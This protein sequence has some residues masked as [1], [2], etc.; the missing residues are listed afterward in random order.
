MPLIQEVLQQLQN[1]DSIILTEQVPLRLSSGR[2][3]QEAA[4][5]ALNRCRRDATRVDRKMDR[6]A[7]VPL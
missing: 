7:R 4:M 6:H 3:R 2:I 5:F 1:H